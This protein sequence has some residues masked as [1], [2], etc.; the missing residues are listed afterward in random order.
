MKNN[1]TYTRRWLRW[2]FWPRPRLRRRRQRALGAY[3]IDF[4][5]HE[6]LT[7]SL[8]DSWLP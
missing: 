3:I 1:L 7:S 5:Y 2:R 6:E 4:Y 8:Q